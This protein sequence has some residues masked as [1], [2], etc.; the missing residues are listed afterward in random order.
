[1]MLRVAKTTEKFIIDEAACAHESLALGS[2]RPEDYNFLIFGGVTAAVFL[3][4]LELLD[5]GNDFLFKVFW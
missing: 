2:L 1:M 5:T 4:A 3:F